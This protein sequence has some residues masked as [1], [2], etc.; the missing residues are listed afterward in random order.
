MADWTRAVRNLIVNEDSVLPAL[1]RGAF[2][3]IATRLGSTVEGASGDA[4]SSPDR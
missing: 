2:M 1:V 3:V 4:D